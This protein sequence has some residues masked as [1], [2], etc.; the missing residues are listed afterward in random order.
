MSSLHRWSDVDML[1]LPQTSM[2]NYGRPEGNMIQFYTTPHGRK[3]G[4]AIKYTRVAG[5][6]TGLEDGQTYYVHTLHGDIKF[7]LAAYVGGPELVISGDASTIGNTFTWSSGAF[8]ALV[9]HSFSVTETTKGAVTHSEEVPLVQLEY[10]CDRYCSV[11]QKHA[12]L[13]RYASV[14]PATVDYKNGKYANGLTC[15]DTNLGTH[16]LGNVAPV[17]KNVR[18]KAGTHV[19]GSCLG[20]GASL[21]PLSITSTSAAGNTGGPTVEERLEMLRSAFFGVRAKQ[22]STSGM[23]PPLS[24][25]M[26]S[27]ILEV[28]FDVGPEA[29]DKGRLSFLQLMLE[30]GNLNYNYIRSTNSLQTF[31]WSQMKTT[32]LDTIANEDRRLV[33]LQAMATARL[34]P[35]PGSAS[36]CAVKAGGFNANCATPTAQSSA[37]DCAS[38]SSS[39]SGAANACD[40]TAGSGDAPPLTLK[41]LVLWVRSWTRQFVK[42]V[43]L[44]CAVYHS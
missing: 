4:D 9:G 20:G 16:V 2:N 3:V 25:K 5:A 11:C 26:Y 40:F 18:L 32:F 10:G 12:V 36:S 19:S 35:R 28:S 23:T 42:R 17:G 38:A 30:R 15:L 1:E 43:P 31:T 21:D 29:E 24:I 37:S 14:D 34:V 6:I 22:W 8:D 33:A 7:T 44:L 13:G 39:V 41:N 27:D